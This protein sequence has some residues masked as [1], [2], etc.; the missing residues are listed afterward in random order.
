MYNPSAI[1]NTRNR[2]LSIAMLVATLG[3]WEG[4]VRLFNVPAFILPPPSA[5]EI[6]RAHV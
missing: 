6:G 1:D 4:S 3:I 5:V 2:L